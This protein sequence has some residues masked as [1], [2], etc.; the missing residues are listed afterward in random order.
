MATIKLDH[1]ELLVGASNFAIWKRGISQ[2][3]QGEGYWGHVEGSP[4]PFAPFP[5]SP[6]PSPP[7]EKSSMEAV[8]AYQEW[9]QK[10]S[11]AR[12]IIE[13]R[14][15][16][17]SLNLLPQGLGVTARAIWSRLNTLY[18]RVDVMS[19][20]DLRDRLSRARLK[21]HTD[22][23]RYVGEFQA[24]RVKFIEMGVPYSEA[25]MVHQ[26]LR[27]LP[28]TTSWTNFKQ[29]LTQVVQDHLDRETP[30]SDDAA[31][32]ML[33]NRIISRLD[34]ECQR[35][36]TEKGHLKVGPGSEYANLANSSAPIRKHPN[37]PKGV[38]CSN[39]NKRSHDADHCWAK[40]GGMEGQGPKTRPSNSSK[41]STSTSPSEVACLTSPPTAPPEVA[42]LASPSP[43]PSTFV[44]DLSCAI[45][46]SVDLALLA[47]G[48][49]NTLMDSGSSSHLVR[50]REFF[51]TYDQSRA[52]NVTTANLG[53][54][55]THAAGD[56]LAK[57]TFSGVTTILKLRDC[58]HAPDACANLISV[59]RMVRA[60]LSCA[61]EDDRVVVSR[62]GTP[63][64][65]GP[66]VGQLF[67]L[68]I[69][70][71]RPPALASSSPPSDVAC[72]TQVPI[73]LDLWHH[74]LGHVGMEATRQFI[75]SMPGVQPL[76]TTTL[77]RCEPCILGKHARHP[78]PSSTRPRTTTLL[79][80]IHCDV[81]GPFP[82]ET[83][84]GK[85]YLII[86][87]D[88]CSSALNL[89]LLASKDQAFDAWCLVQ[90]KWERKLGLKVQRFRCDGGGELAGGSH[91]F[92]A[93]LEA[94]GI[95]RDVTPPYEHWKNGRVERVMRTLQGRILSMLVAAQLPLTY[96]GEA[97][98]TAAY[99]FNLTV[100]ST[101]PSGVTPFE[102]FHGCKPDVSHL[103]VWGVRCFAHVPVELQ[104]K[105]GVKSREC[106]FMGYPPSQRGYRVRDV[107][108]HHFFTSGS[109]IFD[110]NIPYRARHEVNADVDYSTLPLGED[111]LPEV[112]SPPATPP[113]SHSPTAVPP[114]P[115]KVRI[116]RSPR[117]QRTRVLT[118]AGKAYARQMLEA[119]EHLAQLRD[120]AAKRADIRSAVPEDTAPSSSS[121]PAGLSEPMETTSAE[122]PESANAVCVSLD[123][124]A[125]LDQ[126]N[127]CVC[128]A[129]LL[130]IRSDIPRNPLGVDYDMSVPPA[131]HREA[132]ARSDAA[133]WLEVEQKE[134]SMLKNMGVY[135]EELLP[136]GRKAIGCRWVF[137][138]KLVEGGSPIHKA[139]L[140]AQGF[141]QVAFV[142]YNA[143]F[144]PVVKS[145]S[146]RL[147][148]VHATLNDW[149][150]ETFDAT[151]AF[152][153]GD[154]T[155]VIYMRCPPG[156]TPSLPGAVWRLLKSLYGL[157]QASRVWYKLLRK[158]LETLGFI[159]SDFDHALFIFNRLWS[160]VQVHCLVAMHVD[161][162]LAGCNHLSFLIH[163]KAEIR[164]A[165]GIK[166][167]GPVKCFLGVQ[168]ERNQSTRELWLHQSLYID[169]LLAEYGMVDCNSV[170][171][172]LDPQHPLGLE[173]DT[174]VA[175][176][177]LVESYQRLVGSLLFLQMCT[178]PD[179]SFAVLLLSQHCASPLPR[180]FAAARRVLR[181][182]KG[183]KDL[184]LRYGGSSA[185]LPLSGLSDADWAGDK[186]SRASTSAFVWSLA[187]GPVSWS[188]KKQSC[189]ALS[190]AEAEYVALTR[191]VQEGIWIRNSLLAMDL[192]CPSS[193]S[194]S[195]DNL[196]AKSLAENDSSHGRA[197][198]IDIRYHFIRSH[199]E[200]GLF[201]I[202]HVSGS[203]N[204]ADLLTKALSRPVFISH[205]SRLN[206]VSR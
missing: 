206:L 41:S 181:Y 6:E 81:C 137:E 133:Q 148:A 95:V 90:A 77:S 185:H 202:S 182:L 70:F 100:T 126:D 46:P 78:N 115:P 165:F 111:P 52:R 7:T 160:D 53:T 109:V 84:H 195:T 176:P 150:L 190:T 33:L 105:L 134:L 121:D 104:G 139:R 117:P 56:C 75:K 37:N 187:G 205:V 192:P 199:V 194:I 24:G 76:T 74:R 15:S 184:R 17:I 138:F 140:V 71:L 59:G 179:L 83:P 1:I 48:H 183:T 198:H 13:R 204:S 157:K 200:S 130:S 35:L 128:E 23:D 118:E 32:D 124:A 8:T 116:M 61:F 3:L 58:L 65:H 196:A 119:K 27:G 164:K 175:S 141:S 189:V 5:R 20:F 22:L 123:P 129:A 12:T 191:A 66:M 131:T 54:L 92:A 174:T 4:S 106:L 68:E 55:S 85:R 11:K 167:L 57:V 158:V 39:C 89:D 62:R 120:A 86:F 73:T 25:E 29:L 38:T 102:M 168:F 180:H 147:L 203:A 173:S 171:T 44:G 43:S 40:G 101:L 16:P 132:T 188:S 127:Q 93:Q 110:E 49:L 36:A 45:L 177:N 94:Q 152:L 172:P 10:D 166:D 156:Y 197:K 2:V 193:L 18:G 149:H 159:R 112:P 178:R 72:F 67:A 153:W 99:L 87:L 79:E 51:W 69:E 146:V 114:R 19:Q 161:D 80:L 201:V 14:I 9:W 125:Y 151:R 107:Q 82:V 26:M 30:S 145:V 31:P 186:I 103:R 163:I 142:D 135:Q 64:A 21:D 169:T 47:Q 108:T 143:T 88:D 60:G 42:C 98:L 155:R 63:L 50:S 170:A 113:R 154:L 136:D 91:R 34:I 122:P 96:W 97:A 144:A 28:S 162:G